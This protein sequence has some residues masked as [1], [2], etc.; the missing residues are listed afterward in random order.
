MRYILA[1]VLSLAHLF[2]FTV[3]VLAHDQWSNGTPV[4]AWIK[5]Q[6][7]GP[8]DVHHPRHDQV[9]LTP[10]GYKIDG[11]KYLVPEWYKRRSP[12][13]GWWIFYHEDA[14]GTQSGPVCFF[15]PDPGV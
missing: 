11:Y 3:P 8:S 14:D 2:I 4:P 13:G 9:H 10:D 1:S 15:G 5:R 12:D 7:C 6:C